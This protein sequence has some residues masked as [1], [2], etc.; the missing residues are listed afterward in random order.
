MNQLIFLIGKFEYQLLI[1]LHTETVC[2]A[3]WCIFLA[4]LGKNSELSWLSPAPP[5]H[6]KSISKLLME[7]M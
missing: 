7:N 6:L 5:Y 4:N 1:R 2:D 3:K